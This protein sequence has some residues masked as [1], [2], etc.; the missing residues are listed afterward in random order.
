M[1][2]CMFSIWKLLAKCVCVCD[3]RI[4]GLNNVTDVHLNAVCALSVVFLLMAE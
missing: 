2:K 3:D 1:Y 4:S